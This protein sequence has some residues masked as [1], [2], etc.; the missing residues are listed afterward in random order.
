MKAIRRQ[1]TN[2]II[3]Q[4]G[5][6]DDEQPFPDI[7]VVEYEGVIHSYWRPS[8]WERVKILF[9]CPVRVCIASE[10]QPPIILDVEK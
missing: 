3:T 9:G 8:L 4:L 1:E 10:Y 7:P 6:W 2:R 5:S